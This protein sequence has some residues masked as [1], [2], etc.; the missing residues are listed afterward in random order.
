MAVAHDPEPDLWAR[1]GRACHV[2]GHEQPWSWFWA[3]WPL[4]LHASRF[5][6]FYF[7]LLISTV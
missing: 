6:F 2:G 5:A 1:N 3:D 7:M 4:G